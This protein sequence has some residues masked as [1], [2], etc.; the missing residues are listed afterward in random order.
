MQLSGI[1]CNHDGTYS[2]TT[3]VVTVR[4]LLSITSP[5]KLRIDHLDIK[6]TFLNG[7]QPTSVFD[8]H[9]PQDLQKLLDVVGT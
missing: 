5:L 9:H 2:P 1:D 8:V 7:V 6:S 4:L 3:E